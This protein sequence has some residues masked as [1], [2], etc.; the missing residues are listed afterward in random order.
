MKKPFEK[1]LKD[2]VVAEERPGPGG[3]GGGTFSS[4]KMRIDYGK[5]PLSEPPILRES[6]T[7]FDGVT[8]PLVTSQGE[9]S[10]VVKKTFQ[11]R[12]Q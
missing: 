9:N 1:K 8:S 5:Q 11:R 12:V 7:C 2:W 10:A 3:V 6:E 4:T